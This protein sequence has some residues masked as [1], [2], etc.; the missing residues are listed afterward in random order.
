MAY[1]SSERKAVLVDKCKAVLE[2]WKMKATFS[3][4]NRSAFVVTIRGGILDLHRD[5]KGTYLRHNLYLTP[6]LFKG[7]PHEFLKE[8]KAAA[9]FENFD[10]SDAM[11]DYFH[12]GWYVEIFVSAKY[13]TDNVQGNIGQ[14]FYSTN[15]PRAVEILSNLADGDLVPHPFSYQYEFGM[16]RHELGDDARY[17]HL[18]AGGETIPASVNEKLGELALLYKG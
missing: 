9:N 17:V 4:Y 6:D 7:A 5:F 3:V 16:F 1:V 14:F 11:T 10:H 12:V 8:L 15:D 2:K 18:I 13:Q